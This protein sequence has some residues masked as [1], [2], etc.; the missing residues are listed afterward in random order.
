MTPYTLFN[1]SE[2]SFISSMSS[3]SLLIPFVGQYLV[4]PRG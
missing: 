2:Y 3:N 4:V 1:I